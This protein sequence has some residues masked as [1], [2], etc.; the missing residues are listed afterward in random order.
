AVQLSQVA[1]AAEEQIGAG[2][3]SAEAEHDKL[4][5]Q[6]ENKLHDTR[7]E[8][9]VKIDLEMH[10]RKEVE[11]RLALIEEDLHSRSE[12][13][14]AKS[15][16]L[17]DLK[18]DMT[19]AKDEIKIKASE[20][21]KVEERMH[22]S[23]RERAS[24]EEKLARSVV[25]AE[26]RE[27]ERARLEQELHGAREEVRGAASVEHE[28][29]QQLRHLEVEHANYKAQEEHQRQLVQKLME[30]KEE[31]LKE[32]EEEA[33]RLREE[34]RMVQQELEEST[35]ERVQMEWQL[36]EAQSDLMRV[37][38]HFQELLSRE[39]E[40]QG[41][42]AEQ[43]MKMQEESRVAQ[44]T[45]EA[46][47]L[48]NQLLRIELDSREGEFQSLKAKDEEAN[49][50]HF[51]ERNET[52]MAL[53]KVQ[54]EL[55]V[56]KHTIEVMR[57]ELEQEKKGREEA[58]EELDRARTSALTIKEEEVKG[59]LELQNAMMGLRSE[60][61]VMQNRVQ[62]AEKLVSE[63]ELKLDS[64]QKELAE[65][66]NQ[67]QEEKMQ[68]AAE[69]M[70]AADEIAKLK[71]RHSTDLMEWEYGARALQD[72][73]DTAFREVKRQLEK[74]KE[75]LH[76]AV[77]GQ[78]I[79]EK[80]AKEK[81]VEK[82]R[83]VVETEEILMQ[84]REEAEALRDK[85]QEAEKVMAA[86][87]RAAKT[88]E[89]TLESKLNKASDQIQS[90]EE[91]IA[92]MQEEMVRRAAEAHG[93]RVLNQALHEA[94]S[95][96]QKEK[97]ST[98]MARVRAE[99]V[100][101]AAMNGQK[102]M[103]TRKVQDLTDQLK[104]LGGQIEE[105]NTKQQ[106]WEENVK[107]EMQDLTKRLGECELV[108]NTL[109]G[110]QKQKLDLEGKIEALHAEA[111]EMSAQVSKDL[112]K[113]DEDVKRVIGAKE[114]H[115]E[116]V[117]RLQQE[118]I[119]S[120]E[121][122]LEEKMEEMHRKVKASEEEIQ[123]TREGHEA[124]FRERES[125]HRA[126]CTSYEDMI[127]K[128]EDELRQQKERASLIEAEKLR[129]EEQKLQVEEQKMKQENELQAALRKTQ[130]GQLSEARRIFHLFEVTKKHTKDLDDEMDHAYGDLQ[131]YATETPET[132]PE[133]PRL[134]ERS[135]SVLTSQKEKRRK[136]AFVASGDADP[137]VED[138]VVEG[139][140]KNQELVSD[141]ELTA[142]YMTEIIAGA[143]AQSKSFRDVITTMSNKAES[144]QQELKGV[145]EELKSAREELQEEYEESFSVAKERDELRKTLADEISKAV[146]KSETFASEVQGQLDAAMAQ[147]QLD[148]AALSES[149]QNASVLEERMQAVMRERDAVKVQLADLVTETAQKDMEVNPML[150]CCAPAVAQQVLYAAVALSGLCL[151][152]RWP[153]WRG[154]ATPVPAAPLHRN[155]APIGY[156][157]A[158]S[159][160][161]RPVLPSGCFRAGAAWVREPL[162]AE[163]TGELC[164]A[165]LCQEV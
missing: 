4:R 129:V 163:D 34:I 16:S 70:E 39:K 35:E 151:T 42:M 161:T 106:Q 33:A 150:R 43:S 128:R 148:Q 116:T 17:T 53:L 89:S 81:E 140:S 135:K 111:E 160:W 112:V 20:L 50:Q 165:L 31:E 24:L 114:E 101:L 102:R 58:I 126:S 64:S 12:A 55:R 87:L 131:L 51:R 122:S 74:T 57:L 63:L 37:T 119:A 100:A 8:L 69:R 95:S 103:A 107:V 18:E 21:A 123:K 82:E 149:G 94:T 108:R 75:E 115:F 145:R 32:K 48:E 49:E 36:K 96:M 22:E 157:N 25:F 146:E 88:L 97:D 65:V 138:H 162:I 45:Q 10:T 84:R 105:M 13:L 7:A 90:S 110:V 61:Q 92:S 152:L 38:E 47:A 41:K 19:R 14:E 80:E 85:M 156:V 66:Y 117:S 113:R 120:L 30:G 3:L 124:E 142:Q 91:R 144:V 2:E 67:L 59:H 109:M 121:R 164:Q 141:F 104:Q 27:T 136:S 26:E 56:A 127:S 98:L 1:L 71:S 79:A 153:Q 62:D 29:Q 15:K 46:A 158:L 60:K 23:L 52:N 134:R 86:Q 11:H 5:I 99:R 9:E 93:D 143:A 130:E 73:A 78:V 159:L 28:L 83:I 125:K 68:R 54:D 139:L 76:R 147:A 6:M 40:M 133:T 77:E 155:G 44:Q 118:R 132:L 154:L 137:E 72:Q